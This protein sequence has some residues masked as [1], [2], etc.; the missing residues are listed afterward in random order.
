MAN[1][2]LL[3]YLTTPNPTLNCT[4]SSVGTN[5]FNAKWD[6]VTALEDW[7]GFNYNTLMQSYGHI[8]QQQVPPMPG[9]S[10]PLTTLEREIF[11]ENTFETVLEREIMPQVSA[12]LSVAWPLSYLNH[13]L[14]DIAEIT[15]GAK[16]RR[17]TTEEDDR[18]Y[19]DWAGVRKSQT[20]TFG[21]KNLCPGETK[22]ASK[23]STSKEGQR[24]PDY[25]LPFSQIQTYC[26]RQWGVRHGYI[27]TPEEL[28]VIRV[29][30]EPVGPGLAASRAAR[31]RT[32]RE[33]PAHSRTFSAETISSGFQ[34][35]SLDTGSSFSDNANPNIEYGPLQIK[36]VPW[37]AEGMGR[38]TVKLALW[39]L[40]IE[41]GKD[42]SVQDYPPP[43]Q[44]S[45]HGQVPQLPGN[46]RGHTPSQSG[47]GKHKGKGPAKG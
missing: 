2:T 9:T 39:C 46:A 38:L 26:G 16:A 23:W 19:P 8:L 31:T 32:Q 17:G 11:T 7:A 30:R 28:V 44:I 40:H 1:N 27:I 13:E 3:Q 36:S 15:K 47:S 25:S 34:E 4:R 14:K 45:D 41:T 24:R 5:T 33:Q 10:P 29:S 43:S 42:L 6:P 12:A 20:T 35:M 22:L 21:Y 37:S 18:Y